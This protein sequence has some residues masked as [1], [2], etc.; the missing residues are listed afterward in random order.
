MLGFWDFHQAVYSTKIIQKGFLE[1]LTRPPTDCFPGVTV[2]LVNGRY[3]AFKNWRVV[4][5]FPACCRFSAWR[6]TREPEGRSGAWWQN[7][8]TRE[9]RKCDK[10][11]HHKTRPL[12]ASLPAASCTEYT[13]SRGAP[14]R[15]DNR[16]SRGPGSVGRSTSELGCR[17]RRDSAPK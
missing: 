12:C 3:P 17:C 14:R 15:C 4:D 6:S 13:E 5:H 7:P 11:Y 16:H 1:S 2:P 9:P 10:A 8:T